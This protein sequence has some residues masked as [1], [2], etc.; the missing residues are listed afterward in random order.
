MS[1]ASAIIVGYLLT[2]FATPASAVEKLPWIV[3]SP[4][5]AGFIDTLQGFAV[6]KPVVIEETFPLKC[7][8]PSS[9]P[10]RLNSPKYARGEQLRHAR[11]NSITS[12]GPSAA[13]VTRNSSATATPSLV[14]AGLPLTITW[15]R[16]T[17]SQANRPFASGWLTVSPAA[18]VAR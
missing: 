6:G 5:K 12:A 2:A 9:S 18:N 15:P 1:R 3:V 11:S 17:C 7:L 16:K 13:I 4:D 8:T 14:S 10:A